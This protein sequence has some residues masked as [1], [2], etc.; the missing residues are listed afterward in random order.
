MP[1]LTQSNKRVNG[2]DV[3]DEPILAA[4]KHVVVIGGGDTASDC[5]GTVVPTGCAVGDAARHPP[6]ASRAG[7][8]AYGLAVLADQDADVVEPGGGRR[9]RI[10]GGDLGIEGKK[11][12]V[13]GVKCAR[14]D[15]KRQPIPGSE[16]ILKADLV[17]LAIGFAGTVKAGLSRSRPSNSTGAAMSSPTIATT[18]PRATRCSSPATCAAASRWWCGPIREG[19]QAAHSIDTF[20]MGSSDLPR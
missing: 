19:R 14:V 17:F 1:Y 10:P 8:Q 4:G 2:E 11:G 16:F 15:E 6:A 9:A 12:R 7:G 20:L 5:V 13:T 18:G 3:E